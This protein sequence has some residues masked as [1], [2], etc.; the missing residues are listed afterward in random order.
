MGGDRHSRRW[1]VRDSGRR[2]R[3]PPP[4]TPAAHHQSATMCLPGVPVRPS[5]AETAVTRQVQLAPASSAPRRGSEYAELSR[6]VKEAGLLEP[7]RGY[8]IGK[9]AVTIGM[10]VTGW[11]AF[12][13]VGQSWWQPAVA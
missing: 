13:L 9:I 8:Y 7:R 1:R 4:R 6:Q 10:L 11:A 12:V 5:E 3:Q 2:A